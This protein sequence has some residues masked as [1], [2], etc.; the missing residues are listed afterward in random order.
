MCV[1]SL[2]VSCGICTTMALCISWGFGVD[3]H[4]HIIWLDMAPTTPTTHILKMYVW[5]CLCKLTYTQ[6]LPPTITTNRRLNMFS[7]HLINLLQIGFSEKFKSAVKRKIIILTY[8]LSFIHRIGKLFILE[9]VLVINRN[10]TVYSL[11]C[12][13]FRTEAT[14]KKGLGHRN[15]DCC[16]CIIFPRRN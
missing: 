8:K 10:R 12:L 16:C 14:S 2:F 13:N 6:K 9:K 3:A 4:L 11:H 5:T 15:I 1:L 7:V